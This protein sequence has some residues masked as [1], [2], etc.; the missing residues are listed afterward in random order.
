MSTTIPARPVR[1]VEHEEYGTERKKELPP[2]AMGRR[3]VCSNFRLV[4]SLQPAV[5][6]GHAHVADPHAGDGETL[7][8]NGLTGQN[9]CPVIAGPLTRLKPRTINSS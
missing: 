9:G 8:V 5:R 2:R 1:P 3:A 4:P 6:A 7:A